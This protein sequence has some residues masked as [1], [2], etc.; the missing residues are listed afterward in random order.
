MKSCS[1]ERNRFYLWRSGSANPGRGPVSQS[2]R[3]ALLLVEHLAEAGP[4]RLSSIASTLELN[5][6]TAF[7]FVSALVEMGWVQQDPA[8][9]VY[10]LSPRVV[11]LGSM[12]LDRMEIRH[13]VRPHL[14]RLAELTSETVHLGVLDE[15]EMV[16]IDKVEGRQAVS[17]ASRLGARGACHSTAL[18][19]VLLAARPEEEW[20]RYMEN[21]GLT[22]RT[23]H[24][25][26]DAKLFGEELER[27]RQR[28]YA[29]DNV[30]NEDGI[31][32]V[33]APIRDHTGGVVAAMS[34]SG[35]TVSM[36]RERLPELIPLVTEQAESA[37]AAL[38]CPA[39]DGAPSG[40]RIGISRQ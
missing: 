7:R 35:W 18:G 15:L 25:F 10:G 40:T 20:A 13:E 30:E 16:Y 39:G 3:R 12:V 27:V 8:T 21:G 37:S 24:T 29:V 38:G 6:T 26:V 17:M 9:R 36:T 28:G 14:E 33:A 5:K 22:R 4:S 34:V 19:K 11:E 2:A 23:D 32:C 1:S 31:R